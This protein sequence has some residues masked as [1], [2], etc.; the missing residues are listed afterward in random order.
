MKRLLPAALVLLLVSACGVAA[1]DKPRAIGPSAIPPALATTSPPAPLPSGPQNASIYLVRDRHLVATPRKTSV[2]PTVTSLM[3]QLLA[4]PTDV[5]RSAGL[6]SAVPPDAS[7]SVLLTN[8][9]TATVTIPGADAPSRLDENLGFGQIVLTLSA[10][11]QVRSVV[12]V[13]DDIPLDVP[14]AD[15][16]ISKGPFVTSDFSALVQ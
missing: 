6:S 7:V 3:Q 12:F 16:S 4:G 11:P 9:G 14:R 1:E 8:G 15:G 10:S 13:R 2:S 5:E